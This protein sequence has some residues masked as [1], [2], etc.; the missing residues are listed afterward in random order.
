MVCEIV[1]TDGA[2]TEARKA[3]LLA[4]LER[5]T[6]PRER[7]EFLTAFADRESAALRKNFGRLAVESLAW[8]Q[9]EPDVLVHLRRLPQ[10]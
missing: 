1:A 5:S 7:V 2:I 6:L 9:S 10:E 3:S 8:F 4:L